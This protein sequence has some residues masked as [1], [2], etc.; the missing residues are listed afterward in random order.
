MTSRLV[1]TASAVLIGAVLAGTA[2]DAMAA[3]NRYTHLPYGARYHHYHNGAGAAVA[4]AALGLIG[5]A[6]GAAIADHYYNGY[7][8]YTYGPG[9]GYGYGYDYMPGY[10]YYGPY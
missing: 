9:Y 8:A 2:T 10:G 3:R 1:K 6:A 4:G 5:A 7:P